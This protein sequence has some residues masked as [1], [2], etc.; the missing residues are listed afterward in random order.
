MIVR[1]VVRL[2]SC[3]GPSTS[4]AAGSGAGRQREGWAEHSWSCKVW[5]PAGFCPDWADLAER[6]C[7]AGN[8][9]AAHSRSGT[10]SLTLVLCDT[11]MVEPSR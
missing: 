3:L 4:G 7:H 8:T 2:R 11:Q 9:T 6:E 10:H 5:L 1:V